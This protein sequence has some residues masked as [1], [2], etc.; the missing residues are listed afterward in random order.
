MPQHGHQRSCRLNN[1]TTACRQWLLAEHLRDVEAQQ[2]LANK[3]QR[4]LR[5]SAQ[6]VLG[7]RYTLFGEYGY[8]DPGDV[9]SAACGLA[10]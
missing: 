6:H 3:P 4:S 10:I 7:S 9:A 2:I 1:S 8:A 5:L